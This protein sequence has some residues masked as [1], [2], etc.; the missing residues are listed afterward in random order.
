MSILL[1]AD[2][3]NEALPVAVAVLKD[4]GYL[5]DSRNGSAVVMPG[6]LIT[7][8][9]HP[10]F[11]VLFNE[12]RD[13]NPFFHLFEAMWMLAGR[14]DLKFVASFAANMKS[15]SVDGETLQAAYG[16]RWR[17]HFAINWPEDGSDEN[18]MEGER[19]QLAYI[20]R[21]LVEKPSSRQLVLNIWDPQTDLVDSEDNAKDRAC[22]LSVVFTPRPNIVQDQLFGYSLDMTV[23]N[24]SNDLIW[25]AYGANQVHFGFLHEVVAA[26]ACMRQG[27]YTQVGANSHL[28]TEELYGEKLNSAIHAP[29]FYR[30]AVSESSFFLGT[31][32]LIN[33]VSAHNLYLADKPALAVSHWGWHMES[34]NRHGERELWYTPE[35][36]AEAGLEQLNGQDL[37]SEIAEGVLHSLALINP[38]LENF[39]EAR[40]EHD[41]SLPG[42][43]L[44]RLTDNV[45]GLNPNFKYLPTFVQ[46][47]VVP[48]FVAHEH[49]RRGNYAEACH[50]LCRANKKVLDLSQEASLPLSNLGDILLKFRGI[51]E[52]NTGLTVDWFVAGRQWLDRRN[53][54]KYMAQ[55]TSDGLSDNEWNR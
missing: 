8:Y 25:G 37:R 10:Q 38:L 3:V 17:E 12:A 19:D 26:A 9:L 15:F 34:Y 35:Q 41:Q 55:C 4:Q 29:D 50:T 33:K 45:Q 23:C 5:E 49:N 53:A 40:N 21:K 28:Y 51:N 24:R 16:Y 39:L 27:V 32:P 31:S 36:A 43:M 42:D 13:A 22:N 48:M 47:V 6:T 11:R 1:K 52:N 46:L 30:V 44:D 7:D 14:R 54:G 2:T 18:F 20:I